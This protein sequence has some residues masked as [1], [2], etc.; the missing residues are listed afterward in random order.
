MS[1][2]KKDFIEIEF[3]GKI[4]DGGIFD[5]NLPDEVK[6]LNPNT[7][8]E[9]IKPLA[10]C[11]GEGMFLRGVEDFLI[12][13]GLGEYTIDLTP[14]N[15]F[16][17][18]DQ[19]LIQRVPIKLFHDQKINP[20]P[21]VA[22]NFD[23]RIGKILTTSG[24]RVLVDFNNPLAGKDIVYKIKVLRKIEDLNEKVKA[25]NEFLFRH[26]FNFS[27]NGKKLILNVDKPFVDFANLFKDKY[28]DIFDLDL[29]VKGIEE[30]KEEKN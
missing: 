27:I 20:I 28:K 6:K 24:G 15:A 8:K 26:D 11:L 21:G 4:K 16:G 5:S 13:K 14:E 2:K 18:R 9:S 3:T 19:Q 23:G 17:V 22:L 29:E 7:K 25:L 30:K 1:L 12:D 10:I